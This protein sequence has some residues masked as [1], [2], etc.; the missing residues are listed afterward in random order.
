MKTE[1]ANPMQ[2]A[3]TPNQAAKITGLSH[4]TIIRC[5]D[6]GLLK[7]YK[8]P[9]ST[10]RRIP[11]ENLRQFMTEHGIPSREAEVQAAL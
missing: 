8:V 2:T 7:G 9:G 5:F 10:Y 1:M 6:N 4:A 11:I 3:V